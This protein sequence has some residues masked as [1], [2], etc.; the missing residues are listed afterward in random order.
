MAG[1]LTAVSTKKRNPNRLAVVCKPG[2]DQRRY[3]VARTVLQPTVRAAATIKDYAK[4]DVDLDLSGLI[5][6]LTEQTRACSEGD[7]K[8]PEAM[9]TAQAHT[10]DAIFNTLARRAINTKYVDKLEHL[11]EAG[12]AGAVPMPGHLGGAG[13]HQ[14]P[15]S[16]ELRPAGQHRPRAAAGEQRIGRTQQR[17]ARGKIAICKTKDWKGTMA[18]GWSPERRARQAKLIHQWRPWEKSTGPR[19]QAGKEVVSRN[20]YKGGTWRLLRELSGALRKQRRR[21]AE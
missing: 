16:D 6:S 18:N 9:L 11:P 10:L 1:A 12:S 19:T 4:S 5:N 13:D 14:E 15:A 7:L 2:E 8:R 21:L 17:P 20:A 3:A